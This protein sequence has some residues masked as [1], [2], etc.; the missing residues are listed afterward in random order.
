M[1]R[2]L[3]LLTLLALISG[4]AGNAHSQITASITGV[5][6]DQKGAAINQAKVTATR[7][8][9]NQSRTTTTD[10]QGSYRLPGLTVGEY[11]IVVAADGYTDGKR[12]IDLRINEAAKI[13]FELLASGSA[14]TM[15]VLAEG[16]PMTEG[17]NS[18][19][20]IVIE[21]KQIM[22]LPLNGRN[23]LQ[24]G[25][26]VAN[27]NSIAAL[28]SGAEGGIE[29]GPFSV[30]GQRDRSVVFL[31]DGVDNTN[32]MS[33][34][35]SAKVSIEA[36]QEF[37]MITNLGPAEFGYHSGGQVNIVTKSG[38]NDAHA[39]GFEFFRDRRLN[40]A[41]HFEQL[42]NQ[43]ASTFRNHQFGGTAGGPLVKDRVF[44]TG[45][46]EGQRLNV[47]NVQFARVP[48]ENERIGR[49]TNPAT[50]GSVQLP[51]D[52]VS[53][54]ILDRYVPLPNANTPFGNYLAAPEIHSRNHFGLLRVDYVLSGNDV[55][56]ARYLV[57]DNTTLNPIIFNVFLS[58]GAPPGIPGFGTNSDARTHNL[59]L[60]H[61][62]TFSVQTINDF[63]FGYNWHHNLTDQQNKDRPSDLGFVHATSPTGLFG[64][65]NTDSTMLGNTF[66]Y[67]T[68]MLTKNF[69]AADSLSF[70]RGRHSFKV[71]GEAR[72]IR[73]SLKISGEGAGFLLFT[74]AASRIGPIADFVLGVP[75]LALLSLRS[76]G[77]PQRTS[78]Y[79]FFAQDDF[80]LSKRLV[81]NLG[82][83]Y[84]VNTVLKNPT[85][86]FRNYSA[87]RG[88]FTPGVDT[89]T[90]LYRGDHNNFAPRFGFA[91][92]ATADGRTVIRGGY[93][94]YYDAILHGTAST[95]D[96]NRPED[97]QS[98]VSIS[99]L[100]PGR[101]GETFNPASLIVLPIL[102]NGAYDEGVRTPYAQHFNL[103][104]Q[105]E[106]DRDTI[107]SIGYVGSRGTRLGRQRD[108]NRAVYIPGTDA[109]GQ[110]LS[111]AANTLFRRPS[112]LQGSPHGLLGAIN[113]FETSASSTYHSMQ[114]TVTRRFSRGLS[115]LSTYTWAKS[116]D[117]ATDPIGFAG[118]SGGAQDSNNLKPER[119]LSIFDLRHR[120]TAG[121]TY[122]LPFRGGRWT[123]GWQVNGI[124]NLQSGQPFTPILGFDSSL[125]GS[126]NVRPNFV[127]GAIIQKDGRLS[128]NPDLARDPLTQI[129][130]ALIPGPGQFGSLGRNTFIGPSYRNVDLSISKE[131]QLREK[132][133][134]QFRFE[135]FNVLNT[136]NLALPSRRMTD[137]LFGVSTKT[138]DVAGG[139]PGI[140]GGGPRVIQLA[141]KFVY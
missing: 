5:I 118:D 8:A 22:E 131:T 99:P 58:S 20:G 70:L 102:G 89:D 39:S 2:G 15:T 53:A 18:V 4:L 28:T 47:G 114:A 49:F 121:V 54:R 68:E 122:V 137:P 10:S 109:Q 141:L 80:Q 85:H 123:Q 84:E 67:P 113:M 93:G 73:E 100:G 117:D 30:S 56:N 128:F 133:R 130:R 72:W 76:F 87:A 25:T 37:K 134:A 124:L 12:R 81:V 120:L 116:L 135:V 36:I 46:Y 82:L 108:I 65:R 97:P 94:I 125:T 26:L 48:T 14:E 127:P 11:E 66:V 126:S 119:G 61:N 40:S 51:V 107:L 77:A 104:L 27:V 106:V 17:S 132:L 38:S 6:R 69:H 33:N 90:E 63:R 57:S 21:N 110:P 24:L 31:V 19:L 13:E 23:F 88:F 7:V 35:L 55:V 42:A 3:V 136:A 59:A 91:W 32:S 79:G 50:G 98:V 74:G 52:P 115:L 112:Q 75:S 44:F 139:S 9:T 78:N 45:S 140:G 62:H 34:S 43:P 101:L 95:F 96:L 1:K 64:I 138:Q 86:R 71:G 29:N 16:T 129:P 60:S 111:T 41:N 105:R 83:R 92:T 103:T